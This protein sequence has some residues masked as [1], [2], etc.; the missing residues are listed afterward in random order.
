M[1]VLECA[2]PKANARATH[3]ELVEDC[4]LRVH[5][6]RQTV[7]SHREYETPNPCEFSC[8]YRS[9][10]RVHLQREYVVQVGVDGNHRPRLDML[11][12]KV[13]TA[14]AVFSP[15]DKAL[16][17]CEFEVLEEFPESVRLARAGL[18]SVTL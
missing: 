17:S 14:V 18:A 3:F 11:C 9:R 7:E 15:V 10:V 5:W 12:R 13:V 1:A 4:R 6:H 2:Y 8:R 16:S